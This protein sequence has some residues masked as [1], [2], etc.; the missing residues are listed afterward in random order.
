MTDVKCPRCGGTNPP[1][2]AFC[3]TCGTQLPAQQPA[4]PAEST[5]PPAWQ[6]PAANQPPPPPPPSGYQVPPPAYP[7]P[8]AYQP[9]PGAKIMGDNTKWALGLGIVA[10]FCCGPVAGVPG[11]FLAKKDMD[12]IAAG[13]APQLDLGWAKAAFYLNIVALV[14]FVFGIC[15]W[16]GIGGLHRF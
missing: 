13:R 3:G 9:V 4:V 8:G 11:I 12:E 5:P 10:F 16:W 6:P 7:T 15:M 1:T 14:L 2:A